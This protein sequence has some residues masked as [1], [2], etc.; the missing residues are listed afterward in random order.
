MKG[1]NQGES[2][3]SVIEGRTIELDSKTAINLTNNGTENVHHDQ[4]VA[5][6]KSTNGAKVDP[7]E[8]TAQSTYSPLPSTNDQRDSNFI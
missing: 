8:A 5:L 3:I 2:R 1:D 6:E 4:P 7:T